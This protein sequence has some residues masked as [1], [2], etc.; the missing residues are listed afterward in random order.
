MEIIKEK[1]ILGIR[2]ITG[3]NI[4]KYQLLNII[5][6]TFNL[7]KKIVGVDIPH[8]CRLLDDDLSDLNEL[9]WKDMIEELKNT[10]NLE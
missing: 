10:I 6:E 9:N 1:Q 4:S 5:N 3:P 2:H 8:V 7:N